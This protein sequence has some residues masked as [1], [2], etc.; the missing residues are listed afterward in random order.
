MF[1]HTRAVQIAKSIGKSVYMQLSARRRAR[2]SRTLA[3]SGRMPIAILFYHRVADDV[4]NNWT[5]SRRGFVRHL[6]WLE[7]HFDIVG[8][9]E[10]QLRIQSSYN[11]RPTVAIT[12]DDGYAENCD[13]AIPEL[14]RRNIPAT[15]FVASQF[16]KTGDPFAHDV[17]AGFPL[18]PN[19]I[20]ELRDISSRGIEIGAHTKT[21]ADLGKI[22]DD[23][24][25]RD[26]IIGGARELAEWIRRP[27]RYFSF[28]FGLPQN[29]S[30]AAVDIVSE[31]GFRGF[32]SAYGAWNWPSNPGFHLRRIHADPDLESL[33]NW[34]TFD[35]RKLR[36]RARLPFSEQPR[37]AGR[38]YCQKTEPIPCGSLPSCAVVS[39]QV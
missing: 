9:D 10:A 38:E 5:I 26:E 16:V 39:P 28:P 21:H 32:C 37:T 34:L 29:M 18:V 25:V 35:H 36:D 15:Y 17:K 33:R 20:D 7:Q 12:F 30:Q 14:C 1:N 8:L 24:Q 4:V 11:N 31:A 27:I 19:S 6:D 22:H 13:F 23:A 2:L 3:R